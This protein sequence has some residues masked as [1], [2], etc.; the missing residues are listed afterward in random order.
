MVATGLDY[1][2]IDLQTGQLDRSIFVD[3]DIYAEEQEKVFGRAWLMIGHES[4]VPNTNDYFHTY[5]GEEPVI[6]CR[7]GKGKLRAY[8]N[9]C[10]HRGNRIVRT[11][12]GNSRNFACAYHGWTFSNEGEL[13]YLPGEEEATTAPWTRLPAPD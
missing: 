6:L 4:L 9:M 8:L 11:D 12:T 3:Q 7:D 5:M 2:I 10:R 13:E 1:R